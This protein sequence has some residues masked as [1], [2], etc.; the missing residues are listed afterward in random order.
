MVRK[1]IESLVW[2][3]IVDNVNTG[4]CVAF[5]GAGVNATIDPEHAP[6]REPYEGLRLGSEVASLLA[7]SFVEADDETKL[8][9][10]IE[11]DA[12]HQRLVTQL[13]E[14]VENEDERATLRA[15]FGDLFQL[16]AYDLGR[17]ALHAEELVGKPSLV[18]WLQKTLPDERREPSRLL[19][20]LARLPLRVIVTTNYDRLMERA[21]RLEGQPDPV[22]VTQPISGFLPREQRRLKNEL[23]PLIP[24]D[25]SPR[26]PNEP[27]I[28]YK[29]HGTFGDEESGLVLSE[30]DYIEF[31]T[32]MD[33][34]NEAGMPR[35]IKQMIVDSS[36]LFLG[37]SL[38]DWDFR[39]IYKA[40]IERLPRQNKW[41]SYAIQYRPKPFWTEFWDKKA[42]RIYDCHL[43][44]FAGE[45]RRRFE[46]AG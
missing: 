33:P 40:L 8:E 42:V 21:F 6:E 22:V 19:R 26:A 12:A 28:L 41:M 5:L 15:N 17:V 18:Q 1:A 32:V 2:D 4:H 44:D 25:L 24:K 30:D 36:L 23:E 29:I 7:A 10:L 14:L 46:M 13:L 9:Q 16:R 38:E 45:L 27:V 39:T 34:K 20:A 3:T 31:L 37:Y 11:I 43:D 35:L